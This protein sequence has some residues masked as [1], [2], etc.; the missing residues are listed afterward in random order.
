MIAPGILDLT[1]Y[2]GSTF[3]KSF[4]VTQSS[5]PVN[6]TGYTAKM[7]V[8]RY[9]DQSSTALLTLTNGAGITLGG[10]AGTIALSITPTQSNTITAGSYFYDIEL[11]SGSNV[12]R[13]LA[14]KFVVD[15]SVTA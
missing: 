1:C 14:G 15:A 11:T 6:W 13:I 3:D 8:R 5:T 2:Q 10:T 12:I 4:T 9:K 7:Q